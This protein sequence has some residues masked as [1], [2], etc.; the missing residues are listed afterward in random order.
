MP[1]PATYIGRVGSDRGGRRKAVEEKIRLAY[2][3]H[4]KRAAQPVDGEDS[5]QGHLAGDDRA[6]APVC[7]RLAVPGVR[8]AL[9][10][11]A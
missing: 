10:R 1:S 9:L 8:Q 2:G 11:E 6:H 7:V 3:S 4:N 5:R